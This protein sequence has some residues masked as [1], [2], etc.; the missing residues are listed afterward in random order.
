MDTE[1]STATV[2]L[3]DL[4]DAQ[5]A[6]ALALLVSAAAVRTMT[7]GATTQ[8]DSVELR[9]VVGA[10]EAWALAQFLKRIGWSECRALAEDETPSWRPGVRVD[11][12]RLA[13]RDV[14]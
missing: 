8:A 7:A 4:P 10:D 3:R 2:P 6:E 1:E 5:P 13:T 14:Q 12:G 9:V 11:V